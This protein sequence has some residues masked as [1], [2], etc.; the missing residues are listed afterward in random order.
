MI[1]YKRIIS[2]LKFGYPHL[3][4][5]ERPKVKSVH[6]RRFEANDFLCVGLPSQTSITNNKYDYPH[7]TLKEGPKV[8]SDQ[9]QGFPAYDFL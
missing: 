1:K 5:K 2:T 7:L 4:L 8:I 6:T 3:T 9:T